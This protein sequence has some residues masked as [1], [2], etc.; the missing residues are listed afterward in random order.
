[1]VDVRATHLYCCNVRNPCLCVCARQNE[2]VCRSF[3]VNNGMK[4][5][6]FVEVLNTED[7]SF[8][9]QTSAATRNNI[10]LPFLLSIP[11][12]RISNSSFLLPLFCSIGSN[13]ALNACN[14]Q[15]R[16]VVGQVFCCKSRNDDALSDIRA[17]FVIAKEEIFFQRY[18]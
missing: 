5:N 9:L 18:V 13:L 6:K 7:S 14:K 2:H 16:K 4:F 1:M 17:T 3:A 15:R 10:A 11:T 12:C 8:K